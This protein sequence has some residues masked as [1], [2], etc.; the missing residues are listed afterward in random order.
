M[1]QQQNP[2]A[3]RVLQ[4]MQEALMDEYKDSAKTMAAINYITEQ[5]KEP[6]FKLVHFGNVVFTVAVVAEQM[7]EV[8]AMVGGRVSE[9]EKVKAIDK[10][11]DKLIKMLPKLGVRL[12]M[13]VIPKDKVRVYERVFKEYKFKEKAVEKDGKPFVAF[14]LGVGGESAS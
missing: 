1:D 13:T 3:K 12:M 14:Y 7:V 9:K 10:E 5:L 2:E 6:G 4:I 8:H 11:I